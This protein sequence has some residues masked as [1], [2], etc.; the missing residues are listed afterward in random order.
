MD[1]FWVTDEQ[2][3][4]IAP[5][6]PTDTRGTLGYRPPAPEVFMPAFS[7][8]PAALAQPATPAKLPVA[9]RPTVH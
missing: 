6:L 3:A 4:R 9:E 1:Q 5:H 2:F 8:W 7:A